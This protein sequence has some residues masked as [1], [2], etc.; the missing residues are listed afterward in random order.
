MHLK[1]IGEGVKDAGIFGAELQAN[2]AIHE[3][4]KPFVPHI[5]VAL[6]H[7]HTCDCLL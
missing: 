6:H 1:I 2:G 5:A 7:H 3:Q 4:R